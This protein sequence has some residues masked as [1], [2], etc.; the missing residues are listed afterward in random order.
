MSHAVEIFCGTGGVGKTTLAT[1]R[2]IYLASLGR[3]VLLITI[4]PAK[5]LKQVLKLGDEASGEVQKISPETFKL[6][7]SKEDF[8]LSAL[9]MSPDKTLQRMIHRSERGEDLN[10]NIIRVLTS[11][12]GGMNEIMAIIE[13]SHQLKTG[14]FDTIVLDTPPGKHFID[15]LKASEKINQF[16]DKSFVDIFRYLGKDINEEQ[17]EEKKKKS[18]LSLVVSS[19]IKKLLSYLEKVTGG[20]FVND[21]LDTVLGLYKNRASFLESLKLQ[22]ELK[23]EEFCA[24]YL[25]TSAEQSNFREAEYLH[26][27]VKSLIENN[28]TLVINRSVREHLENWTPTDNNALNELRNSMLE[29]QNTIK[30]SADKQFKDVLEFPEVLLESPAEHVSNLAKLWK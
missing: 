1:S 7:I 25:V 16:F 3:R 20:T 26:N 9:L 6:E 24:W 21:F 29:R 27:E 10:N 15:F 13:V 4:D 12:H 19:G 11:P 8:Q 18:L 28:I 23:K 30:E 22:E 5:R 17:I 14:E 2:A